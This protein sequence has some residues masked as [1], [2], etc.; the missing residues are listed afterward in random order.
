[1]FG[2][3]DYRV[4]ATPFVAVVALSSAFRALVNPPQFDGF[5]VGGENEQ[6]SGVE[7]QPLCGINVF[8]D[9]HAFEIIELGFV[10]LEFR[11]VIVVVTR[12]LK[13]NKSS[14]PIAHT[15]VLP[16]PIEA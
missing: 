11:V 5:V 3:A 7:I 16:G 15:E 2:V 4:E 12:S 14:T 10:A 13:D 1:M 9:F 6:I 8:I